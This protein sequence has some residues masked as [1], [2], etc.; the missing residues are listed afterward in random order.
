MYLVFLGICLDVETSH[1][2]SSSSDYISSLS[3]GPSLSSDI[4]GMFVR[5]DRVFSYGYPPGATLELKYF[6]RIKKSA[7]LE[8]LDVIVDVVFINYSNQHNAT[9][10]GIKILKYS[11]I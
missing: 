4:W 9:S 10:S 8:I 11:I 5:P 3:M 2:S 1:I 6:P 7:K